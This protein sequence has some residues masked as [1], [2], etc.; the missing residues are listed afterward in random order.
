MKIFTEKL[1]FIS[2]NISKRI[3]K[4]NKQILLKQ[5]LLMSINQFNKFSEMT[6]KQQKIK[7]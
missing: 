7:K 4:P 5:T 1:F 3:M 6:L 2:K